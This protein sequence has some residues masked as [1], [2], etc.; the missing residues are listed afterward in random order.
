MK[1][2]FNLVNIRIII[3][4]CWDSNSHADLFNATA[5]NEIKV[6]FH[7]ESYEVSTA[8]TI[9]SDTQSIHATIMIVIQ[10]FLK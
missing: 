4:C 9:K 2:F 8:Y 6:A 3:M 10:L 1:S 7:L 5:C